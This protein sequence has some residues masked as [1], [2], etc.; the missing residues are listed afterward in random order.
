MTYGR[1]HGAFTPGRHPVPDDR[2]DCYF[3][4]VD[5]GTITQWIDVSAL[6]GQIDTGAIR[7]KLSG[8]IGG[9]SRHDDTL[10]VIATALDDRDHTLGSAQLGPIHPNERL[11][12]EPED[13][14]A[15]LLKKAEQSLPPG[16]RRIRIDLESRAAQGGGRPDAFADN[17]SLI[18]SVDGPQ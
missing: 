10:T 3:Y 15:F 9:S 1:K 4:G 17:L 7:L 11:Q 14:R 13:G 8:W 5:E 16:T 18:L 6:A 12:A 2:G